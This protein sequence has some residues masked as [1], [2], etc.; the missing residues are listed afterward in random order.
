VTPQFPSASTR[1]CRRYR[2]PECTR[3]P[4]SS[5][6]RG[7][8]RSLLPEERNEGPD[9]P[10]APA[11]FAGIARSREEDLSSISKMG[12]VTYAPDFQ[13]Q[14]ANAESLRRTATSFSPLS[15]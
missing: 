9:G 4:R 6:P 5:T 8:Q 3:V 12:A 15:S 13:S 1:D 14:D 2:D 7:P 10:Y 11:I